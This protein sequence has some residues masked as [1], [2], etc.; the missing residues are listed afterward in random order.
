[1]ELQQGISWESNQAKIGRE[2][3]VL[4]DRQESSHWVG[5]TEYDS[6][7]VDN[8]VLI[9]LQEAMNDWKMG[10]MVKV[11]ITRAEEFDLVARAIPDTSKAV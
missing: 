10:S 3:T 1:M 9:P 6:P 7:E 8:E 4:L 2:F 5:R 11:Q